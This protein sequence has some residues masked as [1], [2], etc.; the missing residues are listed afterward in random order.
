MLEE[1]AFIKE[2]RRT[3]IF[4]TIP[5]SL[6]ERT[7]LKIHGYVWYIDAAII[8]AGGHREN[9]FVSKLEV[10]LHKCEK[11]TGKCNNGFIRSESWPENEH[12]LSDG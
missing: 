5:N 8:F 4:N 10:L 7:S 3:I 12:K 11:A 6:K 2:R 9:K 1:I